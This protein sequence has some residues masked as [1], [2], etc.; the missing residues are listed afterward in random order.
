MALVLAAS[1]TE[2][3]TSNAVGDNP[4]LDGRFSKVVLVD[5]CGRSAQEIPG[6]TP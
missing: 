5:F 2:E 4:P 1:S 6:G 3:R